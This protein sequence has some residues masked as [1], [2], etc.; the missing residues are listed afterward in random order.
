MNVG[1]EPERAAACISR[2]PAVAFTPPVRA[3]SALSRSRSAD[4]GM[5]SAG[6][7]LGSP[8]WRGLRRGYV[9]LAR[10][11]LQHV[12]TTGARKIGRMIGNA[13]AGHGLS[14]LRGHAAASGGYPK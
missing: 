2:L 6:G 3:V 11:S 4:A 8:D 10:S 5:R 12:V 14:A 9:M 7:F 13:P 1:L